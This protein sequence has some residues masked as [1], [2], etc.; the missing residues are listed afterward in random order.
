MLLKII[1]LVLLMRFFLLNRFKNKKLSLNQ[2]IKKVI[3]LLI[4]VKYIQIILP[5]SI[6]GSI[7][8]FWLEWK[9]NSQFIFL[10][11]FIVAEVS[12]WHSIKFI[13]ISIAKINDTES[14]FLFIFF[15]FKFTL[16][17]WN[18]NLLFLKYVPDQFYYY[19]VCFVF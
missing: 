4:E 18:F 19:S 12:N 9:K 13:Y 11:F 2:E 3:Q 14:I 5:S 6:T 1:F 15:W 7:L 8:N 10:I 16:W 17:N